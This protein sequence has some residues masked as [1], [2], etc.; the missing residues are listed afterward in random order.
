MRNSPT[1]DS[2]VGGY[3]RY[4]SKAD[5][6]EPHREKL[7]ADHAGILMNFL[8]SFILTENDDHR[9]RAEEVV[10]FLSST[11]SDSSGAPFFGCQD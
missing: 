8:R 6:S 3:F 4:S 10:D 9:Q 7:L 5:W 1:Y 2:E 11:I